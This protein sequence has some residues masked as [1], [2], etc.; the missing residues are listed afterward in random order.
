[1][2]PIFF[3]EDQLGDLKN[4]SKDLFADE[5]DPRSYAYVRKLNRPK[6]NWLII[7]LYW[8]IP[9]VVLAA[10]GWALIYFGLH[11]PWAVL[12]ALAIFAVY[13]ILM[14]KRAAICMIKIYQRY[15][16]ASIRNNCRFEPS[17]SEYM[18]LSI[19]KYGL[20]KGVC[21]GIGRLRRCNVNG[22]GFDYP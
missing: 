14:L 6:I 12:I 22:G 13:G 21:K 15:T 2:E 18:L 10:L 20:I 16:P 1:M 5:T 3:T 8:A 4:V 17:C 19:Q 11:W 9:V 7:L